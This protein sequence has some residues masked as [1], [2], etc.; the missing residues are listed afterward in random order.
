MN[1]PATVVITTKNRKE[2]LRTALQSV[3]NQTVQVEILVIDDGSTDGTSDM[4]SR[5]FPQ[6][7][8]NRCEKSLGLIEQRNRGAQM[9]STP[10]VI[11]ID[12]DATFPTPRIIEQTLAD[13]DHPRVGAVAIPLFDVRLG[14]QL[15]PPAPMEDTVYVFS[16][17]TGTAHALRR[18]LFLRAGGYHGFLFR[19]GEEGDYCARMMNAGYVVRV[20]R[21]EPIHHLESPMRDRTKIIYYQTRN[22]LLYAWY[23][24]PMP[25]MPLHLLAT[26]CN[27]LRAGLQRGYWTASFRGIFSGYKD[28]PHEWPHRAPITRQTYRLIRRLK[29]HPATR[30]EDILPELP[31]T[32]PS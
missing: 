7:R 23:N 20:G 2:E 16:E 1:Y 10:I 14:R 9:A 17:Y 31:P 12:D 4:V 3:L 21:S 5:D 29:A 8:L 11:S 28:I 25:Y 18:E 26:T 13:I 32:M 6:V 15:R 19:Q 22:N 24:V 27:S 30:L